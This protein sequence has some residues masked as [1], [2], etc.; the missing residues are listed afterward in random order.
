MNT[1]LFVNATID[2]SENLFLGG[3]YFILN[4][5]QKI[6]MSMELM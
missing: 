6:A 1:V 3:I 5:S 4:F 2:F